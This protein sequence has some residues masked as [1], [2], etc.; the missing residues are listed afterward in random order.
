MGVILFEKPYMTHQVPRS[1][2]RNEYCL[3]YSPLTGQ[4]VKAAAASSTSHD[5]GGGNEAAA[6]G[7]YVY[8]YEQLR[9]ARTLEEL[10]KLV[11]PLTN[12]LSQYDC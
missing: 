5:Q 7:S 10:V 4:A 9:G 3:P 8:L 1:H 6:P 12:Y 2:R 11:W